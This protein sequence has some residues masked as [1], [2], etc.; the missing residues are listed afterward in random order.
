M[1]ELINGFCYANIPSAANCTLGIGTGQAAVSVV[2]ECFS[3]AGEYMPV[4]FFFFFYHNSALGIFIK[5]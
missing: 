4:F 3:T 5:T 2:T 1:L